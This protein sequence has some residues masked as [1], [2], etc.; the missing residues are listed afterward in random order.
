MPQAHI[1]VLHKHGFVLNQG[2]YAPAFPGRFNHTPL[3]LPVQTFHEVILG[4]EERVPCMRQGA[5]VVPYVAPSPPIHLLMEKD[6][7]CS[8]FCYELIQENKS[9]KMCNSN[10]HYLLCFIMI[11]TINTFI[12][13]G[14]N[15]L[16]AVLKSKEL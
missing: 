1:Q 2:L 14:H 4:K 16:S 9:R 13:L 10:S 15:L 12:T 3:L 7:F 11:A 5:D 6:L 8:T